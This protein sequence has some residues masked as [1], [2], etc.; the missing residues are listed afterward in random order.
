MV[1]RLLLA[2]MLSGLIVALFAFSFARVY[3]EPTIERAIAL[4]EGVAHGHDAAE[5]GTVSRSTQRNAGLLTGLAAYCAALG[6]VLAVGSACVHGR[7]S[8]RPRSTVW[9]LALIGYVALA[10]VPQLKYPASPPGVGNADTIGSRTQ[11]YFLIVIASAVCMAAS[12]WIAYR[13]RRRVGPVTAVSIGIGLFIA[14]TAVSTTTMPAISETSRDF[15]RGLLFEFRVYAA[16]LQLIVW[17]GLGLLFGQA[18][19]H[20]VKRDRRRE[21]VA[22]HRIPNA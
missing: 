4:E 9:L 18:A 16:L 8:L 10:L 14:L 21:V 20:V 3:A 12:A 11:L 13:T 22:H 1:Q 5:E 15:P 6:G 7:L 2:G 17:G 19:E